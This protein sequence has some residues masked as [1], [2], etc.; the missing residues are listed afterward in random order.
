MARLVIVDSHNLLHRAYH[1]L[2]PLTT[3][4]G[5]PT[6]AALG[7]LNMLLK[8]NEDFRPDYLVCVFDAATPEFRLAVF[9]QYKAQRPEPTEDFAAQVPIAQEL[10][11]ALQIPSLCLEGYEADDLIGALSHRAADAGIE[12]VIVSND[13]DLLQLVSS[14]VR[15]LATGR[16]L[17][18]TILYDP[19][20]V[21]QRFGVRPDQIVDYKA[22]AGDASDNL[23]GIPGVGQK[24]AAKLLQQF[25]SL[26]GLIQHLSEVQPAGLQEKIRTNLEL[27]RKGVAITRLKT[28]APLPDSLEPFHTHPPD[29]D[30]V[31]PAFEKYELFSLLRRLQ[32]KY[33]AATAE[34][35]AAPQPALVQEGTPPCGI[36]LYQRKG[37]APQL[38]LA[39]DGDSHLIPLTGNGQQTTLFQTE[40]PKAKVP[41]AVRDLLANGRL[42]KTAHDSKTIRRW[43][44][45]L[46]CPLDGV[47]F[48]TFLASYLLNPNSQEHPI[49][50]LASTYLNTEIPPAD[51]ESHAAQAALAVRGLQAPLAQALRDAG[52]FSL[53]TKLELP[54]SRV[55]AKMEEAGIAVD[56]PGLERLSQQLAEHERQHQARSHELA[57][58]PF[59][60]ASPKQLQHILF[61][62]LGLPKTRRTK[63]GVSTDE[64]AL[65][66]LVD[67][68]PIIREILGHRM[69]SKLRSTYAD[70]LRKV[71]NPVTGR[72]H[73]TFNQA[74]TAT[75][76]LSSS[77]P[78][79]QNVPIRGEWGTEFRRCFVAGSKDTV[80][81]SAD[82]SQI[83]L[84][85]LAHI[86]QEPMLLRAF[87]EGHDIHAQTASAIFDAPLEKV[88]SEMRR[89]AKTVNFGIL[90]GMGARALARDLGVPQTRA[91]SFISE[92]L[93]R[94]PRVRD[95]IEQSKQQAREFGYV[96][97]LLGRRRP[98]PEVRSPRPQIRAF[99]ERAAANSPLQ[100]T[101]ADIIKIAMVEFDRSLSPKFP[102]AK[103]LLQ[104]HDE[105]L[106]ELPAAQVHDFAKPLREIMESA[107]RLDVPIRADLRYGPNWAD[108]SSV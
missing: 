92:Y 94:L 1:A 75:G 9:P 86:S 58:E 63:T 48:D 70:A 25:G 28:D 62:K 44:A 80:L 16:T 54:L 27:A 15:V 59:N 108:M 98:L 66:D 33:A 18:D 107:M 81:L 65:M 43:L 93:S 73:T 89:Q 96:V 87:L 84:R 13:R 106:V 19:D 95:Y 20:R 91:Q 4:S 97:T 67:K 99:G 32:T 101:A 82:Y 21:Q 57:G 23:P 49:E 3:G 8:I 102:E 77:D 83:E 22:L 26:E 76:R 52:M 100:G 40:P 10:L 64:D 36:Y 104:I 30:R 29:M 17:N 42:L 90:Y 31:R 35:P 41:K 7:L 53:L 47:A 68:H 5:I 46:D 69:A 11:D 55:L 61:E 72:I 103:M 79:L 56:V 2:P 51:H 45:L 38:A 14:A 6:N 88:T 74:G 37:A 85:V 50:R 12:T 71:V 105:L 78:N 60:L 34:A 39:A 24:T